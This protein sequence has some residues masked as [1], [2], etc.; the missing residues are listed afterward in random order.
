MR[1]LE[2]ER[3]FSAW[4][5]DI[6]EKKSSSTIQLPLQFYPSI[7]DPIQQLYSDVD[8][9]SV[10]PQELKGRAIF[11]VNNEGSM[12]INNKVLKFMRR[13]EAVYKAVDMIIIEDTQDQLTF[14]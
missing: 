10:T 9:S 4:L 12:E 6:E 11:T 3:D 8:F 14:P 2:S 1:A 13:N 5:L 7:Q